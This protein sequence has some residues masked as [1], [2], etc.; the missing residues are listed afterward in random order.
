MYVVWIVA[1]RRRDGQCGRSLLVALE[2]RYREEDS[3]FL[4]GLGVRL[5]EEC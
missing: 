5:V 2:D 1:S 4:D 3:Y